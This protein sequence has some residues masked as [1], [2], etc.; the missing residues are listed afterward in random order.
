MVWIGNL[1]TIYG[2]LIRGQ[3]QTNIFGYFNQKVIIQGYFTTVKRYFRK[4]TSYISEMIPGKQEKRVDSTG[5]EP[6]AFTLQT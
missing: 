6:V 3:N 4:G 2:P 5:F 1:T